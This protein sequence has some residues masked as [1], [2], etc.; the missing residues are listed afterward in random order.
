MPSRLNAKDH[1]TQPPGRFSEAALTKALEER[2][3]GRPSTY[4]SIIDTILARQLRLQEGQRAGADLG[5]RSPSRKL[6]EE[7]LPNLVD[8]EFTAQ[9]EDDL[10]AISRGERGHVDY[11]SDFYFGNGRAGAQAAARR[12]GAARSTPA[13]SAAS[14][15]ARP[16]TG[17]PRGRHRAR[18]P[19]RPF[20]EQG[21]RTASIPEDMPP[22]EVTLDKALRNARA[23]RARRRA[24]G[25]SPRDAQAG[26]SEGRAA[27][28]RTCSAAR[29]TTKRSRRTRRCCKGMKPERRRLRDGAEAAHAAA[30]AGRSSAIERADRGLQRPVRTVRQVRRGDALAA[31]GDVAARRDA[32]AGR[33]TARPAEGRAAAAG[34]PRASRSR[35]SRTRRSPTSRCKLLDGR[36]GPYVT[37]GETNASLPKD[38]TPEELTFQQALDL[39]AERA[40][41]GP[42]TKPRRGGRAAKAAK[43][44][45]SKP[46]PVKKQSAKKA[47]KKSGRSRPAASE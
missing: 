45:A 26:L 4:A 37:D 34:P 43:P 25:H 27:S 29:R 47:A 46:A 41:R 44:A 15:S 22:D 2:G 3:I 30:E 14:R 17:D 10:D 7:H 24:A 11:L 9:M 42:S 40:A 36:Y 1:T 16:R 32:R 13:R 5:R 18:R 20:V 21:E 35:C 28:D 8:Y 23:G 39:L 38:V 31:G 12:K 6:L 19:V 33:R